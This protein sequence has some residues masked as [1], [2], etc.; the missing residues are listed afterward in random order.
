MI[1]HHPAA[2]KQPLKHLKVRKKGRL[3]NGMGQSRNGG[4]PEMPEIGGKVRYLRIY[5]TVFQRLSGAKD[6]FIAELSRA[7]RAAEHH[8]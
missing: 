3:T 2:P 8:G 5:G 6:T 1:F 7:K 4:I